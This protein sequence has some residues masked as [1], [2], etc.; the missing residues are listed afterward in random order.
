MSNIS[1]DELPLA[2]AYRWERERADKVFL[3]QPRGGV[4]RD[5]TWSQAMDEA[6]RIAAYL[7]AQGFEP[8]ARIAIISKNSA[9]WVMADL[10]VWMAGYVGVPIYPS[11]AGSTVRQILDHSEASLAFI[12]ELDDWQ[13]MK[14]GIS[15]GLMTIAMPNA[16]AGA[17]AKWDDIIQVNP[18][19]AGETPQRSDELATIIYTSGTTGTPK[20]VMHTFASFALAGRLMTKIVNGSADDRLL[21]YLPLAHVAERAVIETPAIY[22][23]ARMYFTEGLS[24]FLADLRRA[25]PTVFFSVPR[26]WM[27][28][29]QGVFE[30]QPRQKLDRLLRLPIIGRVVKKKILTQLGLE[31]V[32]F[33]G[34]G[35]APMPPE[36]LQWYRQLGL[37]LLEGYGMTENFGLSHSSRPGQSRVGYVGHPW[38][39]VECKLSPE[40]EALVRCPTNMVGYYKDEEKTREA[41][42][43]EG[44]LRTGDLGQI[45]ETG[46]LRIVGRAKEQFK[47]SKGK[48]VAPAPIENKLSLHPSIEAIC[49]TGPSFAQP[50]AI[51]VLTASDMAAA[52]DT[53]AR[54][55]LTASLTKHLESVNT[56]LDPHEQLDFLAVVP[57]P[58][59]VERGFITPTLKIK[60]PTVEHH[61]T[62]YFEE[63][64]KQRRKVVWHLPD[65]A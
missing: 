46:R 30:K 48:Y 21:S 23:G 20:G 61:Y 32:R 25:R 27:K 47:T 54:E 16:P 15:T 63:W 50:F 17:G 11:L 37:E 10:A 38:E 3:T 14:S 49:V 57:E 56:E 62:P 7:K 24:T 33:A 1:A 29:Q 59:T 39:G 26:L 41:F 55:A 19:L 45:D 43:E 51:V 18:P 44:F 6:R 64:L 4:A 36:L 40:G 28:F 8:G 34:C 42:T 65:N 9:W 52:R 31:T 22:L 58:W 2:R 53:T 35:A 12:G 13:A 60:R 5:W